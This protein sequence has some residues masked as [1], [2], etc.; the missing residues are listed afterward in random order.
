M[1]STSNYPWGRAQDLTQGE[2]YRVKRIFINVGHRQSYQSHPRRAESWVIVSGV[3]SI[4]IDEEEREI[5]AESIVMIPIDTKHRIANAS[6]TEP[7]IFIETQFGS[8][9][10]E[11]D[12]VRYEDDF[13][14]L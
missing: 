14:R 10:G 7:L 13:G 8:Y 2:N 9:I 11:D 4:V 6:Q 1:G 5:E 12:I 3:A